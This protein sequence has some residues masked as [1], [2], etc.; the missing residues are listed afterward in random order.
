MVSDHTQDRAGVGDRKHKVLPEPTK[1]MEQEKTLKGLRVADPPAGT[2][3]ED[4]TAVA[5][6]KDNCDWH[7]TMEKP[8]KP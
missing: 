5:R 3:G 7:Q 6:D 1:T 8:S 2:C 4:N